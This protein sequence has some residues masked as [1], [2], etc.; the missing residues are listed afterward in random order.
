MGW[1][2]KRRTPAARQQDVGE[3]PVL[4]LAVAAQLG[5]MVHHVQ[6]QAAGSDDLSWAS[7]RIAAPVGSV[8]F[9][10]VLLAVVA[11]ARPREDVPTRP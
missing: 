5:R 1:W 2:P 11:A 6:Q 8:P 9:R 7:M 3:R 10:S 4:D